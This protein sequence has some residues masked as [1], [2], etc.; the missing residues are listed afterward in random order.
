MKNILKDSYTQTQFINRWNLENRGTQTDEMDRY[1][2]QYPRSTQT[3]SVLLKSVETSTE[4]DLLKNSYY[5]HENE[6]TS[7]ISKVESIQPIA[8]F[9]KHA[10]E[11]ATQTDLN[12]KVSNFQLQ[13]VAQPKSQYLFPHLISSNLLALAGR[14]D[15]QK[16][17]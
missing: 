11:M 6:S 3:I 4:F 12:L 15:F 8:G 17:C 1:K 16:L 14:S 9:P 13:P 7:M 2:I 10:I 5:F